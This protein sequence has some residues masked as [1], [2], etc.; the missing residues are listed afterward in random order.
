MLGH[1]NFSREI[2]IYSDYNHN[3]VFIYQNKAYKLRI[4]FHLN[5]IDAKKINNMLIIVI[6]RNSSQKDL[7]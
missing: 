2:I 5:F 7:G 3:Y 1:S 6:F 4:E